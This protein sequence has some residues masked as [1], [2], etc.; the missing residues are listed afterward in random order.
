MCLKHISLNTMN[1]LCCAIPQKISMI[2]SL[3][4]ASQNCIESG[5]NPFCLLISK[6]KYPSYSG[7]VITRYLIR[8]K[9]Y[10]LKSRSRMFLLKCRLFSS[11]FARKTSRSL[12]LCNVSHPAHNICKE[13]LEDILTCFKC[14]QLEYRPTSSCPKSKEYKIC[15]LCASQEHIHRE[16]IASI[17]S[18]LTVK[19]RGKR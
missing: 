7:D 2:Y 5:A 3:S 9:I 19:Y 17:G 16:C 6:Q 14:Y 8:K 13:I 1:F 12:L 11:K 18:V 10:K 15:S 4:H